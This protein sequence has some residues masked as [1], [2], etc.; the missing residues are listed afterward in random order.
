M[1]VAGDDVDSS[2][3]HSLFLMVTVS[4]KPSSLSV[5]RVSSIS[6]SPTPL[7]GTISIRTCSLMPPLFEKRETTRL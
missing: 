4:G 6:C 5:L 3:R 7:G 1:R 2:H